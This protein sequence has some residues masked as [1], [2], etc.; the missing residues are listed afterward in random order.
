MI[1]FIYAS[2]LCML[3]LLDTTLP[4]TP[5]EEELTL[6]I[7][8][9]NRIRWYARPNPR[10]NSP[11]STLAEVT[12]SSPHSSRDTPSMLST[13]L[14]QKKYVHLS[15][16]PARLLTRLDPNQRPFRLSRQPRTPYPHNAPS[17]R[18]A[19]L[20]LSRPQRHGQVHAAQSHCGWAD[21]RH[22]LEHADS[23]AWSDA[24]DGF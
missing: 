1:L 24:R 4:H 22:P 15:I 2:E 9:S 5:D 12:S 7:N 13:R 23:T 8:T 17:R 16:P 3:F 14:R 19:P 10:P 6:P 11:R 18:S 20:R 21:P